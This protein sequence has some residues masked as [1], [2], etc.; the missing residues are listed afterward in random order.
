M[1]L[2]YSALQGVNQE[3]YEAA[4]IDGATEWQVLWHVIF[5]ELSGVFVI[6]AILA[7]SGSLKSF[8]LVYVMTGGG[9]AKQTYVLSLYM[10]DKAFKGAADYPMAN[11][12]STIMVVISLIDVRWQISKRNVATSQTTVWAMTMNT[13]NE[14]VD[15]GY[16]V[17]V[18]IGA[19]WC[20]T[21]KYND[22]FI[23]NSEFIQDSIKS[24]NV[25]VM[26]VDWANY[27]EQVLQF[28]QKFGRQ[29]LPFYV[30]FSQKFKDGIV[31][32][33]ILDKY[34]FNNLINM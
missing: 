9:P 12:I 1:L 29:G 19:D 30:L 31:L 10:F 18:K 22:K 26:D 28:M 3:L 32:P 6:S 2:Y 17:L 14:Y 5:P 24:N 25:I 7:I 13:I 27:N 23:L 20:L 4:T 8:D 33:E 15:D 21:C 34:E 11:T 16:K